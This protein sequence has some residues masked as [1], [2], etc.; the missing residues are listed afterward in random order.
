M[1]MTCGGQQQ[2]ENR[3]WLCIWPGLHAFFRVFCILFTFG[4]QSIE[5]SS[6]WRRSARLQLG[7]G[8]RLEPLRRPRRTEKQRADDPPPLHNSRRKL[9]LQARL[10]LSARLPPCLARGSRASPKPPA[11]FVAD[12]KKWTYT[13]IG[14][15]EAVE[16][17]Q[18]VDGPVLY[19]S[20]VHA[21][22]AAAALQAA[23]YRVRRDSGDILCRRR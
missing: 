23:G 18:V 19:L 5:L 16:Q 15:A 11:T 6:L 8:L 7:L 9:Q 10:R 12:L 3:I 2:R 14:G 1:N 20:S 17:K 13:G 22:A 21:P 4:R